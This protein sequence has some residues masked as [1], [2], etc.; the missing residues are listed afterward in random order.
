[1][2]DHVC[3]APRPA[4]NLNVDPLGF[5][6]AGCRWALAVTPDRSDLGQLRANAI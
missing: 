2:G 1:M 6:D 3:R 5:S 4:K